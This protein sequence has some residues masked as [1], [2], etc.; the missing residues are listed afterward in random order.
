MLVGHQLVGRHAVR[1]RAEALGIA[2]DEA[3]VVRVTSEV[4]RQARDR[5][6]PDHEVDELLLAAAEA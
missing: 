6:L 3:W 1:Q 5:L 4:K 2:C